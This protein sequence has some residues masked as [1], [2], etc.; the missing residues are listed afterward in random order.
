[1]D[2]KDLISY[3]KG[4]ELDHDL[5]FSTWIKG[6]YFSANKDTWISSIPEHIFSKN[7][8]KVITSI[9]KKSL[10]D[11]AIACLKDSPDVILGY[12]I[13]EPE[14]IHWVYVKSSWRDIGIARDLVPPQIKYA[15]HIT[16]T[17]KTIC[18]RKNIT[19]DPFR[20]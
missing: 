13:F 3:R 14:T 10:V 4:H 17:S 5:I 11:I 1:M 2:K 18:Y 19:F 12:A 8:S 20:I 15:S 7:Y 16:P 9:I 6:L